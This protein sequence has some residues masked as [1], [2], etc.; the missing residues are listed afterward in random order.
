MILPNIYDWR[1]RANQAPSEHTS[2]YVQEN[3]PPRA[4]KMQ[5]PSAILALCL[6]LSSA[7]TCSS[8]LSQV[9]LDVAKSLSSY[10]I[11]QEKNTAARLAN[12]DRKIF[13]LEGDSWFALPWSNTDIEDVFEHCG[14]TVLS[15]ANAGDTL[16]NMAYSNQLSDLVVQLRRIS[17]NQRAPD[18]IYLSFGGNDI[19]GQNLSLALDHRRSITGIAGNEEGSV[20]VEWRSEIL[21]GI[22]NRYKKY[23]IDYVAAVSLTHNGY[24]SSLDR[25]DIQYANVPIVVHGYDYPTA[26]GVG[27]RFLWLFTVKGPWIKPTFDNKMY[28]NSAEISA[29][30]KTLVDKLNDTLQQAV[31]LLNETEVLPGRIKYVDLRGTVKA[32][33]WSD[34]LHPNEIGMHAVANKLL[35]AIGEEQCEMPTH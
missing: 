23:V 16:E 27:F 1:D 12:P 31:N 19:L 15:D 29:A 7:F 35:V 33:Q 20:R 26:S 21:D 10:A 34:E 30:L 28:E 25:N 17:D 6:L 14:Y 4:R 9:N 8:A 3:I 22:L 32:D 5:Y 2:P 18:A 13:L 24:F 11:E